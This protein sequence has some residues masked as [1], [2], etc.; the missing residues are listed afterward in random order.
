[1]K[2]NI[3]LKIIVIDFWI[4]NGF[5]L[6]LERVH[7]TSFDD[8]SRRVRTFSLFAHAAFVLFWIIVSIVVNKSWIQRPNNLNGSIPFEWLSAHNGSGACCDCFSSRYSD[9]FWEDY[10]NRWQHVALISVHNQIFNKLIS[11][12][13]HFKQYKS[14]FSLSLNWFFGDLSCWKCIFNLSEYLVSVTIQF[15]MQF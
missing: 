7:T 6:E 4:L 10:V 2:Q 5:I 9:L 1:M 15:S 13:S 8:H 11:S 14:I 3:W 12:R